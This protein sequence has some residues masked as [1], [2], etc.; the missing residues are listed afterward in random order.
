MTAKLVENNMDLR[1]VQEAE[2]LEKRIIDTN[3]NRL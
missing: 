2:I 3:C 1:T